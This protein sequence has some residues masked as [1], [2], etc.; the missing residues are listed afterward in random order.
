MELAFEGPNI[1]GSPLGKDVS[2]LLLMELAFEG[3]EQAVSSK[4]RE[5]FNPSFNGIGL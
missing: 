2:I 4:I 1:G 3:I 5:C